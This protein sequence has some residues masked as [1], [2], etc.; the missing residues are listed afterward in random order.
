VSFPWSTVITG[1]VGLAGIGGTL[2]QGK[3]ARE[4]ASKDLRTSLDVNSRNLLLS[5]NAEND[6][7]RRAEKRE[8]YAGCLAV[9]TEMTSAALVYAV[10]AVYPGKTVSENAREEYDNAFD[11]MIGVVSQAL[12]IAPP[13]VRHLLSQNVT[14]F[15]GLGPPYQDVPSINVA[16]WITKLGNLREDLSD[17]MRAD[18][19]DPAG[20]DMSREHKK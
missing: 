13:K 19:E 11:K 3:R 17:A 1:V 6:R 16:D 4:T 15:E 5:I 20:R 8:I 7:Q 18:L 14:V 2:W 10:P 9:L 12:L